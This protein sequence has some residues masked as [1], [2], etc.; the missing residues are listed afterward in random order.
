MVERLGEGH[1]T[2]PILSH[3]SGLWK[4]YDRNFKRGDPSNGT[5]D[6]DVLCV[7]F[8]TL[9]FTS[10]YAI[11][12][13]LRGHLNSEEILHRDVEVGQE[14]FVDT[15]NKPSTQSIRLPLIK[16]RCPF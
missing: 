6:D 10:R 1:K 14:V 11:D 13:G 8:I 4:D 12:D 3:A 5:Q 7:R 16:C 2:L 9:Y 15:L